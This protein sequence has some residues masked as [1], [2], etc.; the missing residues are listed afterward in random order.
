[1]TIHKEGYTPIALCILFIFVLNAL[2]QFYSPSATAV[3]W[4]VYLLSFAFFVVTILFFRSPALDIVADDTTVL[5]PANGMITAIDDVEETEFLKSRCTRVAIAIS[6][7]DVHVTRNAV[8]GA[9]TYFNY[10]SNKNQTTIAVQNNA[11]LTVL[12]R[13]TAGLLP[14]PVITY[15][16]TGDL[17][18]Q[19]A[20]LGFANLGARLEVFLPAGAVLN[21]DPDD[22]VKGGQTMLAE[23]RA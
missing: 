11:G 18:S 6:A 2:I 5:C 19:G 20:Q 10:D 8:S 21:V 23:L 22:K 15:V 17:V 1:M 13:Q 4:I 7:T 3:K 9:V 12:L 14:Q 16:K